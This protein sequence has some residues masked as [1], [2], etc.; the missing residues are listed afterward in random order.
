MI[1]TRKYLQFNDLVLDSYDMLN[2]SPHAVEFKGSAQEYSFGHGSYRPIK[3]TVMF[4]RE[5]G[6]SLSIKLM[7]QKIPCEYREFYKQFAVKETTKPGRLWAIVNNGLVWAFAV[8]VAYS[9]NGDAKRDEYYIELDLVLPEGVWHKADKQKTFLV[10]YNVCDFMDCLGYKTVQPCKPI[11]NLDCCDECQNSKS[12]VEK[13]DCDCC[14]DNL[15]MEMALCYHDDLQIFYKTCMPTYQIVYSC[16]KGNELFGDKFLGAKICTSDPCNNVIAGHF[17]CDTEIPTGSMDI[18]ID[19]AVHDVQININ[20]NMNAIKGDYDRL[21]IY[22]NGDVYAEDKHE[23]CKELLDPD[24][25]VV[26]YPNDLGWELHQGE[27][28]VVIDRGACCG[29]TCVYINPDSLTI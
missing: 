22:A 18:V 29:R 11:T 28:R 14:C 26:P 23:C 17:Y 1:Y 9:E 7:M 12:S 6:V 5:Q 25:W 27:N 21:Y 16:E 2:E 8:P 10:P 15:T 20:G 24:V 13:E 3:S 19:G 4:A